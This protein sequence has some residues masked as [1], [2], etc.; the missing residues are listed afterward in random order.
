MKRKGK[1]TTLL[2]GTVMTTVLAVACNAGKNWIVEEWNIHKLETGDED[3]VKAAA[4]ILGEFRSGRAV[5]HLI[6]HIWKWTEERK[7][8]L[9]PRYTEGE[10]NGE[11]ILFKDY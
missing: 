7:G 10:L 5:P 1:T 4:K 11:K 6:R 8:M 2:T 9:I 3:E